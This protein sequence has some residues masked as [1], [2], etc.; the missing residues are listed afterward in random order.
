MS[1]RFARPAGGFYVFP[2]VPSRFDNATEF[3]AEA[4]KR[5]VLT[6]PGNIFSE[7]DSHFRISYAVPDEKIRQGC[8]ILCRL[9][10][11]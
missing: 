1:G 3:V 4:M 11:E 8:E 9:A 10:D 5:N 6:I 7:R 2:Q